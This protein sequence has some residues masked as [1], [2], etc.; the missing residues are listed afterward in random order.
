MSLAANYK[1]KSIYW[2]CTHP[3]E[4]ITQRV[5][6]IQGVGPPTD[7]IADVHASTYQPMVHKSALAQSHHPPND[8][9]A[10]ILTCIIYCAFSPSSFCLQF[11]FGNQDYNYLVPKNQLQNI[12]ESHEVVSFLRTIDR[13]RARRIF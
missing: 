13:W 1:T 4:R 8:L 9:Y 10:S 5:K 7:H 6:R 12:T 3:R 2:C 11:S